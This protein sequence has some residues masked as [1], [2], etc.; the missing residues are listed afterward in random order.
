[1]PNSSGSS[2]SLTAESFQ[3]LV[4]MTQEPWFIKFYAPWCHHCQAIQPIWHQL[5][6]E[7]K[8]KLNIGEVNCDVEC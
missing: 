4:T 1:M 7:M 5:G 8:G 3:N 6:K 2:I